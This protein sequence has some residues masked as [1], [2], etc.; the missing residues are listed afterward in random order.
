MNIRDVLLDVG[1]LFWNMRNKH[2]LSTFFISTLLVLEHYTNPRLR[3]PHGEAM[4][5]NCLACPAPP[6][7]SA[8]ARRAARAA[9]RGVRSPCRRASSSSATLVSWWLAVSSRFVA[10]TASGN[11]TCTHRQACHVQCRQGALQGKPQHDGSIAVCKTDR[12]Q[13]PTKAVG[14]PNKPEA[15]DRIDTERVVQ[16]DEGLFHPVA[17]VAKDTR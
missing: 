4:I 11:M 2:T 13:R 16:A 5:A 9:R 14:E 15:S 10:I 1:L 8:S 7:A 17:P 3:A 6:P 12:H